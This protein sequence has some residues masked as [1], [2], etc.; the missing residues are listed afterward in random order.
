MLSCARAHKSKMGVK[1]T[2]LS[3]VLLQYDVGFNA[4]TISNVFSKLLE[5]DRGLVWSSSSSP[6]L[7]ESTWRNNPSFAGYNKGDAVW[8]NTESK[9]SILAKRENDILSYAKADPSLYA[10]LQKLK[11]EKDLAK[12]QQLLYDFAFAEGEFKTADAVPVFYPGELSNH[13]QVRVSNKDNN[14]DIPIDIRSWDVFF[15]E[16]TESDMQQVILSTYNEQ[17]SSRLAQHLYEYHLSGMQYYNDSSAISDAFLLKDFS[18]IDS[19]QTFNSH[20]RYAT[21]AIGYDHVKLNIIKKQPKPCYRQFKIWDSGYL[22]HS[23][24]INTAADDSKVIVSDGAVTVYLDWTYSGG[25]A[26]TYDY[27]SDGFKSF[28]NYVTEVSANGKSYPVQSPQL[29]YTYR[30][31]VEVTPIY[32]ADISQ[33]Y[34]TPNAKN[35]HIYDVIDVLEM[36]NTNFSFLANSSTTFYAYTVRGYS[37]KGARII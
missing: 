29:W 25:T 27:P 33:P 28:Y 17:I 4:D 20:Y 6:K 1:Y 16:M 12:Y 15:Y 26:P 35:P 24:I 10:R 7:W 5:N 13:V 21:D 18:N 32:N 11:E 36:N 19:A 2:Q 30:Y 8:L 3:S 22:E 31:N 14:K 34:K 37:V 23:G 9:Q